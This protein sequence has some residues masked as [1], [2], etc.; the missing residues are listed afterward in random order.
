[1][2]GSLPV[3]SQPMSNPVNKWARWFTLISRIIFVSACVFLLV[4]LLALGISMDSYVSWLEEYLSPDGRITKPDKV[5]L[6]ILYGTLWIAV[7]F[8]NHSYGFFRSVRTNPRWSRLSISARLLFVISIFLMLNW[9]IFHDGAMYKEDG[10]FESATACMALLA[11][12]VFLCLPG[13]N[14]PW[15]EKVTYVLLGVAFVL[16]AMEEI[17]WGQRLFGWQTPE[18]LERANIQKET[19]LH[20]LLSEYLFVPVNF[21]AL[22]GLGVLYLNAKW[23]SGRGIRSGQPWLRYFTPRDEYYLLGYTFYLLSLASLAI[24][25]EIA[26]EIMALLGLTVAIRHLKRPQL[27]E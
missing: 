23:L 10:F 6:V 2:K 8:Y 13:R 15:R 1:M 27:H 21:F 4:S 22:L 14:L 11:G 5:V 19:N 26:E 17:S 12:V 3:E 9:A 18:I 20:N 7:F 25:T 16:F 24:G